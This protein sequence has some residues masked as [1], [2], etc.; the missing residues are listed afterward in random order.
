MNNHLKEEYF[1]CSCTGLDHV[2]QLLY[3]P[4]DPKYPDPEYDDKIS[5]T[6]TFNQWRCRWLPERPSWFLELFT[7]NYWKNFWSGTIWSKIPIAFRYIFKN[8]PNDGSVLDAMDIQEKDL[9]RLY[10]F[11][12]QISK[13]HSIVN[14]TDETHWLKSHNER[15][16]L[17]FSYRGTFEKSENSFPDFGIDIQFESR[18][19]FGRIRHGL[20]YIFNCNGCNEI[21]FEINPEDA[22]QIKGM[23]MYQQQME[24]EIVEKIKIEKEEEERKKKDEEIRTDAE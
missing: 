7:K 16:K 23:A 15:W 14:N 2:I 6:G 8:K 18:K 20:K 22:I 11:L 4:P 1:G 17:R 10:F 9:N 13:G 3:S 24:K 5:L 21:G 12:D 19:V